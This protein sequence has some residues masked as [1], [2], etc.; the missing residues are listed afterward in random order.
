MDSIVPT[1]RPGKVRGAFLSQEYDLDRF[2]QGVENI[3]LN[4]GDAT[5]T[6]M[7]HNIRRD[8]EGTIISIVLMNR[9]RRLRGQLHWEYFPQTITRLSLQGNELSGGVS[10]SYLSPCLKW[11]N[12]ARNEFSGKLNLASL[13]QDLVEFIADE[14]KFDGDLCL[15]SL[16][17]SLVTL[18][19][20]SNQFSGSPELRMLPRKLNELHLENNNLEG[21][22]D[23]SSLPP[24]LSVLDVQNNAKI[25]GEVDFSK[26]PERF[27]R[28]LYSK[29]GTSQD[30]LACFKKTKLMFIL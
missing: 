11:M 21:R 18:C 24:S 30:W 25:Y 4:W 23:L 13:P 29:R 3:P 2:F 16:P 7:W 1:T 26:L 22:I 10:F 8:A 27:K 19:L 12:I 5:S 17:P 9:S 14:N 28:E 6:T 20:G 15:K